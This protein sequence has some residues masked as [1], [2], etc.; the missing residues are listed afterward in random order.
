[1]DSGVSVDAG[2]DAGTSASRDGGTSWNADL[3]PTFW[4]RCVSCHATDGGSTFGRPKFLDSYSIL[5]GPSILCPGETV[6]ICILRAL[7]IQ[8][9]ESGTTDGGSCRTFGNPFHR[10]SWPTCFSPS[11]IDLVA[12]WIDAGTPEN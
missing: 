4:A 11:E 9:S 5:T 7:E 12:R 3:A 6:A 1:M 10:E 8:G 2:V